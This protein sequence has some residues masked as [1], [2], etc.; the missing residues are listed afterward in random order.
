[1]KLT[2]WK[3]RFGDAKP[4]GTKVVMTSSTLLSLN[5]RNKGVHWKM[6]IHMVGSIHAHIQ[7]FPITGQ[8]QRALY[9]MKAVFEITLFTMY[10]LWV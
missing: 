10:R 7:L 3:I 2:A 1:M 5:E 4:N 8:Q 9:V 6:K